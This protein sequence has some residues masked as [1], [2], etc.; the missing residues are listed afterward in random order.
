MTAAA[1]ELINDALAHRGGTAGELARELGI[2]SSHLSNAKAGRYPLSAEALRRLSRFAEGAVP[3]SYNAKGAVAGPEPEPGDAPSA[4]GIDPL[5]VEIP[6]ALQAARRW[7]LWRAVPVPGRKPRKVPFYCD[8]STRSGA[9][10]SPADLARLAD[11]ETAVSALKTGPYASIGFA[12]GADETGQVWQGIDLDHIDARPELAALVD[13]LPGYVER[14]PSGTGVHAIGIGSDFATL[15]S[16]STGIEAYAHGR[17]FTVT[18]DAIGGD[19]EDLEPFVRGTLAPLHS[20]P[21]PRTVPP[22]SE[23][24]LNER[25]S[26][27]ANKSATAT[28]NQIAELRSALAHLRADDRDLWVRMGHALHEFGDT[29]R[30]LWMDWSATSEKFDPADAARAWDSFRPTNTGHA[31]VFAEAQRQGWANPK[32]GAGG[33]RPDP[34]DP[35]TWPEPRALPVRGDIGEA[36]PFPL[37][38]LPAPLQA[39]AREVA[40]FVKAPE[41]S[42][43][44]VGIGA[45]ATAIGKRALVVERPGLAHHPALFLTGIAPS[46]ERKSPVF[47]AMTRPLEDWT[48]D[49]GEQWEADTRRAKARNTAIDAALTAAKGKAKGKAA[50]VDAAAADIEDLER[51]REPIPA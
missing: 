6:G 17:F 10:D 29:G 43:A 8:G 34:R 24:T 44:L 19:P 45:L 18:G 33:G 36:S 9:L 31:A 14:S 47:R 32:A 48:E 5:R 11:F 25:R 39:A 22:Q 27:A 4:G 30:G 23:A 50:N 40:R 7:L 49:Q 3:D 21:K 35:D 37:D 51:Q 2:S 1:A 16:N 15:G 38:L 26:S 42:A 20:P 46:G 12:L 13:Q 41:A 28:P